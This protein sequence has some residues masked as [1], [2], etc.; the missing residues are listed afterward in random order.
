MRF[1][2]LH[3]FV[4]RMDLCMKYGKRFYESERHVIVMEVAVS[5]YMLCCSENEVVVMC[6]T[7][8]I[9]EDDDVCLLSKWEW[10]GWCIKK[11]KVL[12]LREFESRVFVVW[13]LI[14]WDWGIFAKK[15][16][17][18]RWIVLIIFF[19]QHHVSANPPFLSIFFLF[20][21]CVRETND[22]ICDRGVVFFC[23]TDLCVSLF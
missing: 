8:K 7:T 4:G 17:I 23:L 16:K 14:K 20:Q 13:F 3:D 15:E 10:R 1:I 21:I 11:V 5:S 18:G 22:M 19:L 2:L 6:W 9:N 12:V